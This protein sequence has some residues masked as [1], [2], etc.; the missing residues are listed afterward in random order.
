MGVGS[1]V[2]MRGGVMVGR[3]SKHNFGAEGVEGLARLVVLRLHVPQVFQYPQCWPGASSSGGIRERTCNTSH[4][5][6]VIDLRLL[7]RLEQIAVLVVV[8]G[9]DSRHGRL[10]MWAELFSAMRLPGQHPKLGRA[11]L[12]PM[13]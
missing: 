3:Q 4:R 7:N 13:G 5:G 1:F 8:S 11:V 9:C 2:S 10:Q 6:V 12:E